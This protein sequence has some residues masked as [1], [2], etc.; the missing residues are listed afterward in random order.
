MSQERFNK[1]LLDNRLD[2]V[3]RLKEFYFYVQGRT[4]A[5]AFMLEAEQLDYFR[6]S[7]LKC[8]IIV[9]LSFRRHIVRQLSART[10][11]IKTITVNRNDKRF[12]QPITTNCATL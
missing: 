3:H 11:S 8:L 5:L 7:A 2:V 12:R 10:E 6:V 4:R 1:L 9:A